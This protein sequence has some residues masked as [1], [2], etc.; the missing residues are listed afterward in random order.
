M[1]EEEEEEAEENL[2]SESSELPACNEAVEKTD[3][4]LEGKR[5]A[6][7]GFIYGFNAASASIDFLRHR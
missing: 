7:G 2:I 6:D 5:W 3:I 1:F 4:I